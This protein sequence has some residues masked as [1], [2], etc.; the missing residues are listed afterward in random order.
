MARPRGSILAGLGS[1]YIEDRYVTNKKLSNA[2]FERSCIAEYAKTFPV[3]GGDF[4][5]YQFPTV[6]S[7]TKQLGGAS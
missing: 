6:E 7:F 2:K 4:S 5:L 3:V 1:I